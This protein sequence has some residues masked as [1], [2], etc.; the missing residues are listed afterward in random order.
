MVALAQ[1]YVRGVSTRKVAVI[2][3]RLCRHE[4]SAS[5]TSTITQRLDK[6]VEQ[7][8]RRKL[9]SEFPYVVVDAG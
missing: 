8:S 2:T 3:E 4:F 1:M 6:Q 9:E 7:F 5:S